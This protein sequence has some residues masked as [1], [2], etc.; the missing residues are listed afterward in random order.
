MDEISG[1]WAGAQDH[2]HRVLLR[3]AL[4]SHGSWPAIMRGGEG[5]LR[6]LGLSDYH[7][8]A[9]VR[10]KPRRTKGCAWTL[11]DTGYPSALLDH[12]ERPPAALFFEGDPECLGRRCVA[13]VG[14][15]RCTGYGVAVAD[16]LASALAAEGF[17]IVS[18][19]A[20]G[21]DSA[22]HRAALRV[23]RTV[24]VL[25]HGLGTTSPRSNVWL[26]RA[27]LDSG[28]MVLSAWLDD[29]GP[30]RGTFPARNE[31]IAGLCEV[32]VVVEAPLKSGAMITARLAGEMSG[33]DV[34]AVPGRL[35]DPAS[36]GCHRL[37]EEGA[38]PLP[39]VDE[40]VGRLCAKAVIRRDVWL[41][42]LFGGAA[43]HDVAAERGV[44]TAQLLSL[45]GDLE[46]RGMVVRLPGDRYVP[47]TSDGGAPV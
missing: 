12:C 20:R 21:I 43:L 19:L 28:G 26:R 16:R 45:L 23:G 25:G 35:G 39:D 46:I 9:W 42:K 2:G 37:L 32:V 47:G 18:G 13:I 5:L 41:H 40:F 27:I 3:D 8:R 1:W 11:A 22:A 15:R 34:Y 6:Q 31:W 24:A 38:R 4:A 7:A 36:V 44:S 29:F 30:H 10:S 14:T 33:V 17:T